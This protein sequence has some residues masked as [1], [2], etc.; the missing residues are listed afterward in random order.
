MNMT[1]AEFATKWFAAID[2]DDFATL[3]S[4]AAPDHS[5]DNGMGPVMSAK[6]HIGSFAGWRAAF[7]TYKHSFIQTVSE[8]E[9]IAIRGNVEMHHTGEFNGIPATGRTINVAW[10]DVMHIKDG[11]LSEEN[12]IF[13]AMSMMGQL[14]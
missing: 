8:G 4:M 5:F 9:W 12:M 7:A 13:N 6:E 10:T 3:E 1:N 2:A 14:S 11:K